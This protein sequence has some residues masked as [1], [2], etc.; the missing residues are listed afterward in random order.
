MAN[1]FNQEMKEYIVTEHIAELINKDQPNTED[2][3]T[4][5]AWRT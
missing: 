3:I 4:A 5:N 2:V 1:L